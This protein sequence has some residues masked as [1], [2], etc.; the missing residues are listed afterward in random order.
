MIVGFSK[1]TGPQE[2][3][4]FGYDSRR[5]GCGVFTF[6]GNPDADDEGSEHLADGC[7]GILA[8]GLMLRGWQDPA[9]RASTGLGVY[10]GFLLGNPRFSPHV[11]MVGSARPITERIVAVFLR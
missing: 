1:S 9:A 11:A 5:E 7:H 2:L 3:Q 6:A 10:L 4:A 8:R